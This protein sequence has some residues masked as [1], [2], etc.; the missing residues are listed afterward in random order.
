MMEF[1]EVIE[2]RYSVRRFQDKPVEREK[3]KKILEIVN[4]APSAGNLQS[5]FVFIVKN[6]EKRKEIARACFNQ[7]FIQ[8]APLVLVFCADLNRASAYGKRGEELYSLQDATIAATFAMLAA[9]DLGLGSV[10]IGA[11][12][13]KEIA[14]IL[15]LPSHLR[16][17]AVLPIGYPAERPGERK[18]RKIEDICREV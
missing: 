18:R 10:W 1:E 15:D 4:S 6:E 3:L 14:E 5:Y 9:V 7:Y 8:E 2:K 11:F 16:P 13:E 17:V 12:D